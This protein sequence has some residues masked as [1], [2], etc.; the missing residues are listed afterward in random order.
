MIYFTVL[1]RLRDVSYFSAVIFL[2]I[3]VMHNA[4]ERPYEYVFDRTLDTVIGIAVGE[5]INRIQLPRRKNTN[6][7]YAS[8][9]GEFVLGT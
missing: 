5:L 9:I 3:V 2:T 1:F 7:L 8:G 4:D 6:V